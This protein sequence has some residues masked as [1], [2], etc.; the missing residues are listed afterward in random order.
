MDPCPPPLFQR[1]KSQ[2]PPR[3][4]TCCLASVGLVKGFQAVASHSAPLQYATAAERGA[5]RGTQ[6]IGWGYRLA[7]ML[8]CT[9]PMLNPQAPVQT[10]RGHVQ[11][12]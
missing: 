12:A 2:N 5:R 1:P 3:G 11:V 8:A 9:P 4:P 6:A 10:P 7:T